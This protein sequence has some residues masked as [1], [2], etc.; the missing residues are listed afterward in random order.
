MA[1]ENKALLRRQKGWK[2][3]VQSYNNYCDNGSYDDM[4]WG[5]GTLKPKSVTKDEMGK[6]TYKF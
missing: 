1:K 5:K 4:K 6:I 2:G 3:F